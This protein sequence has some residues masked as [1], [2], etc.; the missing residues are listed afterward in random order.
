MKTKHKPRDLVSLI[1][2]MIS[3][4]TNIQNKY[5]AHDAKEF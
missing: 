5:K 2:I 3:V 1:L 4:L